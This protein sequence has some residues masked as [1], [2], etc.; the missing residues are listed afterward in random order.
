QNRRDIPKDTPTDR[1][2]VLRYDIR[3]RS[4]VRMGIMPTETKLTLEQTQQATMEIR[5]EPSS[6]KL[7]VGDLGDSIWIELVTLDIN[8][9]PE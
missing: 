8:L 1:L 3:K 7:L 2:E 4:K 9:G 5:L 6:I